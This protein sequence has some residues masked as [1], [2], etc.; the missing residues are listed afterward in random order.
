MSATEPDMLCF[1][2][3]DTSDASNEPRSIQTQCCIRGVPIRNKP[4]TKGSFTKSAVKKSKSVSVGAGAKIDQELEVD[5]L[6]VDGWQDEHSGVIRLYFCFEEQFKEI[7]QK[8][9]TKELVS[10][11]DG[12]LKDIRLDRI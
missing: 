8:G 6:G 10:N 11:Q 3:L 1:S 9:G 5:D 2:D 12:Y 4:S 7:L